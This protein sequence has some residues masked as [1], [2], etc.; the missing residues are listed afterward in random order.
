[1]P[2]GRVSGAT[3]P[4]ALALPL[5][6]SL[7]PSVSLAPYLRP[8][9]HALLEGLD[10]GRGLIGDAGMHGQGPGAGF[11]ACRSRAV[12]LHTTP[13]THFPSPRAAWP[14]KEGKAD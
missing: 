6:L 10:W 11:L 2:Q 8:G 5:A 14:W 7:A 9:G 4:L 3:I 13:P 12:F 1:M